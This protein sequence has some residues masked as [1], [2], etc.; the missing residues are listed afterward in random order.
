MDG[1]LTPIAEQEVKIIAYVK[2]RFWDTSENEEAIQRMPDP[3]LIDAHSLLQSGDDKDWFYRSRL[4]RVL[5]EYLDRILR[6]SLI[7][8][9]TE[10]VGRVYLPIDNAMLS[11]LRWAMSLVRNYRWKVLAL[12]E[13]S[14]NSL[15]ENDKE[16]GTTTLPDTRHRV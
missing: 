11:W 8:R 9:V 16:S 10:A 2:S 12:L 5:S 13:P 6:P 7:L 14:K 3:E 1:L 4:D 15:Q